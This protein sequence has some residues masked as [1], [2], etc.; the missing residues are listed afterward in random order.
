MAQVT[1][2]GRNP[3][4][5][6]RLMDMAKVTPHSR[7]A[8]KP[9]TE[10]RLK[11]TGL[12]KRARFDLPLHSFEVLKGVSEVL[13]SLARGLEGLSYMRHKDEA[14]VLR[15]ARDLVAKAKRRLVNV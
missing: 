8:M 4:D 11:L 7:D 14:Q 13:D 5:G 12:D 3:A 15:E 9:I 6:T 1:L 10:E 2:D